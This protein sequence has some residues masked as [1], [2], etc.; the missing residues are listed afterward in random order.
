MSHS[1]IHSYT[2]KAHDGFLGHSYVGEW[3]NLGAMTTNSN[4]KITY[5]P[6]SVQTPDARHA[7]GQQF[8]GT[9]LGDHVKTAVGTVLHAGT[10]V[11]YG[12]TLLGQA[13]GGWVP[14]FSWGGADQYERQ[15]LPQFLQAVERMMKRRS[16]QLRTTD[17]KLMALLFEHAHS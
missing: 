5:G 16:M 2:N 1:V 4:L 9:C 17:K 12:S 13:H 11:G 8:F 15:V 10:Q 6:I 3:V 7:S 14:P